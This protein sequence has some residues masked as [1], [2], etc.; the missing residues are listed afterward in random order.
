MSNPYATPQAPVAEAPAKVDGPVGI[1]GWLILPVIGLF[2]FPL[3]AVMVLITD[4]LPIFQGG[5]WSN[6]TTP[7]AE[8]YHALWAP[9]ILYEIACNVGFV[10]FDLALL[11]MLFGKSARFPKAF[12]VFALLNLFFIVSDT[13]LAGQ[14]PAVAARGLEGSAV[15]IARSLVVVAIWVPYMLMSK[16]VR[17]TFKANDAN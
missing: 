1:G 15:E 13:L 16:R 2:V 7:G 6:L 14:I 4:F 11:V 3:R 12:I 8:H 17:N 10:V 9:V 5:A